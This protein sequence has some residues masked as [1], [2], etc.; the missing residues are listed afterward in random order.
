MKFSTFNEFK[1]DLK[2]KISSNYSFQ[3]ITIIIIIKMQTPKPKN[4]RCALSLPSVPEIC[5][6]INLTLESK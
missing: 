6:A 2:K 1:K 5:Q 3:F 4:L